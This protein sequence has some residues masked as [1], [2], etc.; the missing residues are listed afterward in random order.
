[1][2]IDKFLI[3]ICFILFTMLMVIWLP[4]FSNLGNLIAFTEKENLFGISLANFF[5]TELFVLLTVWMILLSYRKPNK[6]MIGL[7]YAKRHLIL[8]SWF[9][10]QVLVV[11]LAAGFLVHQDASWFQMTHSSNEIMPAQIAIL[12]VC[13]PGYLLFGGSAYLYAKTRLPEFL[14][15]K[16][17]AFIILTFAPF[18]YLPYYDANLSSIGGP[19][20]QGE[21]LYI[22]TYWLISISW[23]VVGVA[24]L[25]LQS[26]KEIAMI[27]MADR[28]LYG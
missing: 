8:T 1:M 18:V 24:Y 27:F 2:H 17:A 23:L 4:S 16:K 10:G 22:V 3:I 13:Y 20:I 26:L 11:F 7:A 6:E 14:K 5:L 12:L 28:G 19:A 25:V 15:D 21:A 9:L